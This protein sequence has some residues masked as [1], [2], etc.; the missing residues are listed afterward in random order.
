V[1]WFRCC[2]PSKTCLSR[3]PRGIYA[4][5]G[6]VRRGNPPGR[7]KLIQPGSIERQV[8]RV[9]ALG[10]L[11]PTP[12]TSRWG[13]STFL[14]RCKPRSALRGMMCG[15]DAGSPGGTKYKAPFKFIGTPLL[16]D[17]GRKRRGPE[18]QKQRCACT[19][20]GGRHAWTRRRLRATGH[21]KFIGAGRSSRTS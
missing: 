7:Q 10:T 21:G 6:G 9:S 19:C 5:S 11:I 3:Y 16:H 12:I 15:A 4:R 1:V 20:R 17:C 14:A 2:R 8:F 13:R 18:T